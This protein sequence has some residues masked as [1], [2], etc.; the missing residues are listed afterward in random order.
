M[1]PKEMYAN[2]SDRLEVQ[3][4]GVRSIS[5]QLDELNE[6]QKVTAELIRQLLFVLSGKE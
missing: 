1:T 3:K 6:Y 5:K 4:A 2:I